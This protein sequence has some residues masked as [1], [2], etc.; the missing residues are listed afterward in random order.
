MKKKLN[1]R[2]YIA[3]ALIGSAILTSCSKQLDLTP[4]DKIDLNNSFESV[5][6]AANWDLGMYGTLR[7]NVYGEYMQTT[8]I[9]SDMLNATLNYGNNY[10]GTQRWTWT[11]S[12]YYIQDNWSGFYYGITNA[13]LMIQNFY[14]IPTSSATEVSELQQYKGDAY[15]ARA[16]YYSQLVLRFCKPYNA[17]TASTDLGLPI[18]TTYDYNHLSSNWPSRGTV[19]DAYNL[20][21]SDLDSATTLL[22]D[23][24]GSKGSHYF[25]A[26]AALALQA[27]VK[28]Y[29]N[30]YSG[31][32]TASEKLINAGEYP[33]YSNAVDLQS[34]WKN[35]ASNEDIVQLNAKNPNE[36]PNVNDAYLGFSSGTLKY[37]PLYIPS[38]WVVDEYAS[39][40]FRRNIYV[41]KLPVSLQGSGAKDSLWLVNKF[42]GNPSLFTGTY[43]NYEQAPKLFRIAEQYLIDAEASYALGSEADALKSLNALRISRGLASISATGTALRDS[44]RTE[45]LRELAFEGFRIDDLKRWNLPLQRHDPQTNS[46]LMTG[47]QYTTL[48]KT[49]GDNMFV[50]GIPTNDIKVNTKLVQ[51]PGW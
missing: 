14:K 49:A 23:V 30:D 48:S 6:D 4:Y 7:G 22:S 3:T 19:A 1:Y 46:S 33:L 44:V 25:T 12:D 32:K 26:D 24:D 51:N 8:D 16:Y 37:I 28:L 9:Q 11:S 29:M 13:N 18:V 31:A 35:D 10:G 5:S 17:S 39:N 47:A 2:T 50:W 36:V 43:T 41:A 34:M 15:L 40:D 38:Q 27:R 42:P 20:I 45:R 21:L